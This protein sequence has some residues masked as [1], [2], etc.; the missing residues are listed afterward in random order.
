MFFR[1]F[2]KNILSPIDLNLITYLNNIDIK[3]S[4][5]MYE[6]EK[7]C[8]NSDKKGNP[9]YLEFCILFWKFKMA[10]RIS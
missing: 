10:L 9:G 6:L 5:R 2:T 8:R 3:F 4:A 1:F 7:I